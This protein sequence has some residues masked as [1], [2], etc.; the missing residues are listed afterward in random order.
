MINS[1][2]RHFRRKYPSGKR[3]STPVR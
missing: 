1:A 2:V 3:V